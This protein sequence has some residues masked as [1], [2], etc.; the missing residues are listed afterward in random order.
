MSTFSIEVI[1]IQ[2][3]HTERN[4]PSTYMDICIALISDQPSSASG[5]LKNRQQVRCQHPGDT[6]LH[7]MLR[8][9]PPLRLYGLEL[10]GYQVTLR[11]HVPE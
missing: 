9:V 1:T 7:V 4:T 5:V 2:F 8:S 3:S 10:L 6:E 11:V